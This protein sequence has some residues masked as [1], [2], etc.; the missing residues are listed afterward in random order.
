[1]DFN[2]ISDGLKKGFEIW[3]KNMVAFIVGCLILAIPIV[4]FVV[5]MVLSGFVTT[6]VTRFLVSLVPSLFASLLSNFVVSLIFRIIYVLFAIFVVI[7]LTLGL[8]NMAFKGVRGD[9]VDF[10]DVFYA[11]TSSKAYIRC[12]IFAA[13]FILPFFIIEFLNIILNLIVGFLML[14]FLSVSSLVVG[15]FASLILTVIFLIINLILAILLFFAPYIFV[16]SPSEKAMYAIKE[17]FKTAKTN[18]IMTIVLVL[19]CA[20]LNIIGMIPLGL[21]LLLTIPLGYMLI[22]IALKEMRPDIRD[23]S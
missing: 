3:Q 13:T 7:P 17:S 14:N 2:V 16:M 19:V 15:S 4:I 6:L 10:K 9:T 23:Q 21:G 5:F 1:M 22:V 8:I 18:L 12:A 20:I 11:F